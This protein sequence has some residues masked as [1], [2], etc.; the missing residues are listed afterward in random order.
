MVYILHSNNDGILC[1]YVVLVNANE[2]HFIL[3]N[4]TKLYTFFC[5]FFNGEGTNGSILYVQSTHVE[6]FLSKNVEMGRKLII[7]MI[8]KIEKK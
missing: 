1:K 2:I 5:P 7:K 8:L 4:E 3:Q 6:G